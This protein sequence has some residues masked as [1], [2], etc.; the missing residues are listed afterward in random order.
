MSSMVADRHLGFSE[1]ESFA[2]RLENPTL[3][4]NIMPV[5]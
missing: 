2:I 1:L 4:P 3:E 5:S